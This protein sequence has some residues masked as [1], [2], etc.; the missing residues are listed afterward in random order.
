MELKTIN[1]ENYSY[2]FINQT[3]SHR[4]GFTHI[5]TLMRNNYEISEGR[6]HWCNRTWEYYRYETSMKEAVYN[7]INAR[8]EN[9]T[10]KFRLE[11]GLKRVT[12]K[13][14]EEL[15]KIF[16]EDSLITEYNAIMEQ[17]ERA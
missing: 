9:L 13:R 10:N 5:S 14:R 16:A 3:R 1:T 7:L 15:E 6:A 8:K 17:L 4:Y 12:A 11:N 2:T